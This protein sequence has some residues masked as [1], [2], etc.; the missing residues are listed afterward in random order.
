MIS[1]N[2]E[3]NNSLTVKK[4]VDALPEDIADPGGTVNPLQDL[5]AAEG[6]TRPSRAAPVAVAAAV[7]VRDP[8]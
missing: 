2:F 7:A 8:G 3:T 5:L 1:E 6:R 4:L